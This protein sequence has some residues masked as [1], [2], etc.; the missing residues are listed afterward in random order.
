ML[1]QQIEQVLNSYAKA[2]NENFSGHPIATLLRKDIPSS[3]AELLKLDTKLF[4]PEGS[5]GKGN[6]TQTPWVAILDKTLTQ[7]AMKGYYPVISFK[8]DLSGFYL[9]IGFGTSHLLDLYKANALEILKLQVNELRARLGKP[10]KGFNFGDIDLGE[11]L[12]K[13]TELFNH[14]AVL[15]KYF[16]VT[17]LPTDEEFRE[18]LKCIM[19][20]YSYLVF[21]EPLSTTE[22]IQSKNE[23]IEETLTRRQ[24]TRIERNQNLIKKV[25]E[26]HGYTCKACDFNFVQIYGDIGK[27]YIEAHHLTP[28]SKLTKDCALLDPKTDFTVLCSN[29]HRMIHKLDNCGDIELLKEKIGV[30]KEVKRDD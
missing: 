23:L 9:S 29:C 18:D 8:K 27:D 6:W 1:V 10:P 19:D 26:Y 11:D 5:P 21:S 30:T 17:K 20:V 28:I 22:E 24:H 3:V 4:K 14:S 2:K 25:K 16:S 12:R 13:G 7:T 15:S